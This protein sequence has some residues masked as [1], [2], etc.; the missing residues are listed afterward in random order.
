[1]MTWYLIYHT[2]ETKV[3]QVNFTANATGGNITMIAINISSHSFNQQGMICVTLLLMRVGINQYTR[4]P[5]DCCWLWNCATI[6]T[7]EIGIFPVS[8]T[9]DKFIQY[10]SGCI[11]SDLKIGGVYNLYVEMTLSGCKYL[12][13]FL[14]DYTCT[15]IIFAPRVRSCILLP[16]RNI[17]MGNNFENCKFVE[18]YHR[19]RKR[20]K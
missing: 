17:T 19:H 8:D 1:M 9:Q 2:R 13:Q 4:H 12:C 18:L 20:G 10:A 6:S 14:H 11:P 15:L 7:F 3:I 16:S 5:Q